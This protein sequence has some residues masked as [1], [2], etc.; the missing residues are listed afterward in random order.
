M[1]FTRPTAYIQTRT[2]VSLLKQIRYDLP[3]KETLSTCLLSPDYLNCPPPEI[4]GKYVPHLR[5]NRKN[6]SLTLSP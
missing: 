1:S 2:L 4:C 6:F 3:V 5:E